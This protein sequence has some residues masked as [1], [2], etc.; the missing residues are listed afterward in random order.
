MEYVWAADECTGRN[1]ASKETTLYFRRSAVAGEVNAIESIMSGESCAGGSHKGMRVRRVDLTA[2]VSKS[3][4]SV[5]VPSLL[6]LD[7]DLAPGAIP[8]E[9]LP[10]LD[11]WS[12]TVTYA[13]NVTAWIDDRQAGLKWDYSGM[14][15]NYRTFEVSSE[16]LRQGLMLA[17]YRDDS[18]RFNEMHRNLIRELHLEVPLTR[19]EFQ[20]MLAQV[21]TAGPPAAEAVGKDATGSWGGTAYGAG[22]KPRSGVR[23]RLSATPAAVVPAAVSNGTGAF[24]LARISPGTYQACGFSWDGKTAEKGCAPVTIKAGTVQRQ[25][26]K[27]AA[28]AGN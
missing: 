6:R 28:V 10:A 24:F 12:N 8:M 14:Q 18:G 1:H 2:G 21:R 3:L 11:S 20:S 25:D 26:L 9:P 19:D 5:R 23:I 4:Y 16:L 15:A 22:G 27:L 17:L 7:V 13:R